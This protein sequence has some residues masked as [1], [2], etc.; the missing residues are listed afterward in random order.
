[1]RKALTPSRRLCKLTPMQRTLHSLWVAR[2]IVA[3]LI[4]VLSWQTTASVL[5]CRTPDGRISYQDR[6]CPNGARGEPVDATPN[7][8]FRFATKQEI[9]K[10][11][12][13]PPEERPPR[14]RSSKVKVRQIFNA[15]ERRF[16]RTGMHTA[17]VRR[18][19]GA[20][21]HI[22]YPSSSSGTRPDKNASQRWIYLPAADDPQ[23]TT[24]L[25]VRRGMVLHV[26]RN[27]TR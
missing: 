18:R 14:V 2:W 8:G 3:T 22:A 1:M 19:I 4:S 20:P 9:D 12:R 23:T 17:E 26:E 5:R 27:V 25:T 10:A 16:I 15:D 11:M 24:T 6:S 7:Q 21:D 13:P